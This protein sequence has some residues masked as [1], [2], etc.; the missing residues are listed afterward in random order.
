MFCRLGLPRYAEVDSELLFRLADRFAPDG[1]I[2]G[3]SSRKALRLCRGQMSAVL[4]SRLDP[5]AITVIKGNKPLSRRYS[6][7]HWAVL[8]TSEPE[9]IEVALDDL[10][11][12]RKLEIPPLTMLTFRHESLNEWQSHPFRFVCQERKGI[13]PEGVKA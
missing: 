2:N 5:G 3:R 9:Y 6:R 1:T 7:K 8:Y 13:L 12:W 10:R 4:A 11:G